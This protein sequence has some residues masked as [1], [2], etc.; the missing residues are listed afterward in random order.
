MVGLVII[1]YRVHSKYIEAYALD[2]K[3]RVVYSEWLEE[4]EKRIEQQNEWKSLS[5]ETKQQKAFK[6]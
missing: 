6:Y 4:F 2:N 3:G 1:N 5:G